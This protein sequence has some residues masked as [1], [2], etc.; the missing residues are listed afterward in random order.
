M[1]GINL[2]AQ[3]QTLSTEALNDLI[4][5]SIQDIKGQNI[6]KLDDAPT[7]FFI[8]CEGE[9]S[10]Q[11]RSIAENIQKR[12]KL[13]EDILSSNSEGMQSAHWICLDY[14]YTV[15]HIFYHETRA[16]YELEDLWSDAVVTEYEN[17]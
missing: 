17:L 5:D 14:F 13:E 6:W 7:D 10:V 8:I 11:V 9:S 12:L 16:F 1:N 4:V 2:K 3:S 15:V